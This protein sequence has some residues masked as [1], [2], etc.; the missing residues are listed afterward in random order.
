MVSCEP[1][2][3]W[4]GKTGEEPVQTKALGEK[5]VL[6]KGQSFQGS[7]FTENSRLG[8]EVAC[9]CLTLIL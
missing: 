5:R 4:L 1:M 2:V 8:I 9:L 6:D 3:P 7:G